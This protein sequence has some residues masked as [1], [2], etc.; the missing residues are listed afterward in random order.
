MQKEELRS[1]AEREVTRHE[2]EKLT[3]PSVYLRTAS[4][5]MK[6]K[7]HTFSTTNTGM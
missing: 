7:I 1:L 2:V 3:L 5:T 4:D 6:L